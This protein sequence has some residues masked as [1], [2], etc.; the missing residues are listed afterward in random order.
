[1]RVDWNLPISTSNYSNVYFKNGMPENQFVSMNTVRTAWIFTVRLLYMNGH[2]I[3][4]FPHSKGTWKAEPAVW[5]SRTTGRSVKHNSDK[6]K[7]L[8]NIAKDLLKQISN[9]TMMLSKENKGWYV[10]KGIRTYYKMKVLKESAASSKFSAILHRC[11][12]GFLSSGCTE[13]LDGLRDISC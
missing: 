1:M 5:S 6:V 11:I 12:F 3:F 10:F 13:M 8:P 2:Y 7:K 9:I 4:P